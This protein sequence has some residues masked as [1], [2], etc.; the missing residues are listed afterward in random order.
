MSV[1]AHARPVVTTLA[2]LMFAPP[3]APWSASQSSPRT[4]LVLHWST[5]DF[6]STPVLNDAIGEVF[7]SAVDIDDINTEYLES[8]RFPEPIA[9]PALRDYIGRKYQGRR[10]DVVLAF[11]EP[12]LSF[13]LRYRP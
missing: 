1:C 5:E 3:I 12:A 10:I 4:V 2:L 8:D 13:A 6:P 7:A 11:S 9:A